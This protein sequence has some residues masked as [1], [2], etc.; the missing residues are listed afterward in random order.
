MMMIHP[1]SRTPVKISAALR[2]LMIPVLCLAMAGGGHGQEAEEKPVDAELQKRRQA[3]SSWVFEPLELDGSSFRLHMDRHNSSFV[4]SLR[5]SNIEYYSSWGRKGFCS[6]R[7]SDGSLVPVDKVEDLTA[8]SERIRFRAASSMGKIPAVWIEWRNIKGRNILSL[9]FDIPEESRKQVAGIRLLERAL[10]VSDSDAGEVLVPRGGG[11][12]YRAANPAPLELKL[13]DFQASAGLAPESRYSLPVLGLNRLGGALALCWKEPGALITIQREAVDGDAFPGK[14]G[15]FTSVDFSGARAEL[16]FLVPTEINME[17]LETSRVYSGWFNGREKVPSLR[18][19]TS[20]EDSL[21]SFIAAAMWRPSMTAESGA[22]L[23]GREAR[24]S[25]SQ[26]DAVSRHWKE[27][28]GIEHAA[29]IAGDWLATGNG[30]GGD[31]SEWSAADECGGNEALA[32][33]AGQI[34]ARGHLFG[35]SLELEQLY[36]APVESAYKRETSW[37]AALG[38]ARSKESLHNLKS[39]FDPQLLVIQEASTAS[40][41]TKDWAKL[42]E[43]RTALLQDADKIFGLAGISP[44]LPGDFR[45]AALGA[46]ALH[47]KLA[48]PASKNL[49]PLLPASFGHNARLSGSPGQAL[50]PADAAGFLSYLLY[51]QAP[52]YQLPPGLYFKKPAAPSPPL[53]EKPAA[54]FAREGGWS[55]GRKLTPHD[56]FIKNTYEVAAWLAPL[57]AR[58]RLTSHRF[59][60]PDGSVQESFFSADLRVVVNFGKKPWRDELAKVVLPPYGFYVRHPFFL[61]FC[62]LEADGL[63]YEQ[64]AFFTVRSLEGKMYLRAEQ[65]R[66]YQGM[67][68]DR[69]SL[70]GRVFKVNGE[71]KTKIW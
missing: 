66:I 36:R 25:F 57:C 16:L 48:A 60:S 30:E 15:I 40:S 50:G 47:S 20:K 51:G 62:A 43:S 13:E 64:P 63:V 21:R 67:E 45:I 54:I 56:I 55:R 32:L 59:L 61:A 22:P 65:V 2:M 34:R 18:Y 23:A 9:V 19:K 35:L 17:I 37:Q 28:L 5:R 68:P 71:L 58:N 7:L 3:L 46:G 42:L 6:L 31:L 70:G 38:T 11:E 26:L 44:A 33:A 69:I 4:L 1:G 24:H 41:A 49:F 10:W 39:I 27:V 53:Q 12:L 52:A 8:N 14:R 29:I